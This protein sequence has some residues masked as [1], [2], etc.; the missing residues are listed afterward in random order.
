MFGIPG[1]LGGV[2]GH[3]RMAG[4]TSAEWSNRSGGLGWRGLNFM[5]G[6]GLGRQ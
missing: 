3:A 2:Y 5:I 1:E 4:F 6:Q